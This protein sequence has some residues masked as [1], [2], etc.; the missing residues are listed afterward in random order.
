MATAATNPFSL[1]KLGSTWSIVLGV[2]FVAFGV[3][4]IAEPFLAAIALNTL[5]AWLLIFVGVIHVM[6]AFHGHL[7]WG[8]V[9]KLLIGAAYIFLGGYLLVRPVQGV[10]SLTLLLAI[11]FLVEGVFDILLWW[12]TRSA[13]GASWILVDAIVTLLLGGLI[14]RHWPNS[15]AWAIGTLVG[16]S[17]IMSGVTRIMMSFAARRVAGRLDNVT[18]MAA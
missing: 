17:M 11:L 5:I 13:Q 1:I 6:A 15:S 4:A 3:F 9:W 18:R 7:G 2:L 12:K 14:Y 8:L 10:I 16:V